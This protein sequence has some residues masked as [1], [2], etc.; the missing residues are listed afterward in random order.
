M[1]KIMRILENAQEYL[2]AFI[3]FSLVVVVFI[4]VMMRY[5]VRAS[6]PWTEEM[7]RYLFVW[8]IFIGTSVCVKRQAHL[9]IDIL[10]IHLPPKIQRHL[11]TFTLVLSLVFSIVV[12][13]KG[14]ELLTRSGEQISPML[15]LPMSYVYIIIPASYLIICLVLLRHIYGSVRAKSPRPEERRESWN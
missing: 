5:V 15:H 3:M 9:G 10:V 13:Q 8:L 2:A 14:Y 7:A 1:K 11:S 4:Q 6:L 12:V